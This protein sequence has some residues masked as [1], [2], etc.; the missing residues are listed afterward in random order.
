MAFLPVFMRMGN[1]LVVGG[2][3]V[4]AR[5][6][7]DIVSSGGH[8]KVVAPA[9]CDE[10]RNREKNGEV[11]IAQRA[12]ETHDIDG[13]DIVFAAT[14]DK[15]VD[16]R[17]ASLCRE[18]R[19]LVNVASNPELC[20]F[21]VPSCV[22][23]GELTV[24]I[25]TS[26]ASPASSA[27]IRQFIESILPHSLAEKI[28]GIGLLRRKLLSCGKNPSDSEEYRREVESILDVCFQKTKSPDGE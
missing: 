19:V 14:D 18:K 21:F 16:E 24:A 27:K 2:G 10:I 4:A 28:S 22:R 3:I 5:K 15:R 9:V 23:R 7:G 20:D 6:V 13:F 25:G 17:V 1:C 26:G 11:A 12:F 8:A